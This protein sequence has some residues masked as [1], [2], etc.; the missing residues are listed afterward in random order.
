MIYLDNNA[1]TKPA[2]EVVGLML[3]CLQEFFG[4]PSSGHLLG[5]E[6]DGALV[7]ARERVATLLNASPAE[8]VFNS[9]GTEGLN[10]AF[11]GVFEA[12]PKKRHFV[13]TAVEHSATLALGRWLRRQG[14]EVTIL[15]VDSEGR[16]DLAELE[17]AIRPDTALVSI[18]AANNETGVIFPVE[19]AGALVKSKGVLFHVDATQAVGRLPL[20]LAALPVDLLN[21]SAHKFHGPKGA[22]ALFIRRGLRISP[23][24]IGGHQERDRRAGTENLPALV[25]MGLAAEMAQAALDGLALVETLRNRLEAAIL[26]KVPETRVFG[27]NAPRLPNTSLVGFGG[28]DG[29][30]LQLRLSERG[31][32]CSTGSACTTGQK[33]PSHVLQAM[34]VGAPAKGALRFSLSR[35]TTEGEIDSMGSLLPGMVAE[36]RGLGGG[37]R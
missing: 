31:I 11:R 24:M 20:D 27:A 5:I 37:L 7:V 10:H 4:N 8:I 30:A 34:G 22:G 26:S 2:P 14:A 3:P 29:E 6:A 28:L 15:G 18:M 17:R 21:I 12:F 13:T 25:G 36:I 19:E 35:Y 23:F 16:L 9:G 33:E 1:T 32:C